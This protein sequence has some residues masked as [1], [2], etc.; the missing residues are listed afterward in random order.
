VSSSRRD[1]LR[2]SAALGGAALI[3]PSL[4]GLIARVEGQPVPRSRTA[5]RGSGGYGPLRDAGPELALPAGFTYWVLSEP[6]KPMSDGRPTPGAF[7][8]MAAFPLP[9]GNIRLIRNHENRD[10]AVQ[11]RLK[12]DPTLAYDRKGGGGTTSL[13]V[14]I[15]DQGHPEVV[16]DFLSLS[17]TIVNCAG[18]PTPWGSWLTCEESVAGSL[19]GFEREH[20]YVFEVPAAATGE[21]RAVPLKAMGRFEHEAVAIDPATGIVY[22]TEDRPSS[23]FYRFLPAEPGRLAAG[24]RLEMLRVVGQPRYDSGVGQVLGRTLQVDWV[25]IE[26]PDPS[27]RTPEDRGLVFLEGQSRGGARFARLEG[28]WHGDGGIFFHATSGGDAAV[29]QVWFF[30]PHTTDR[31]E[32]TLVFESP[33]KEVLNYPDNVTVSPRGGIVICEDGSGTKHVR[34]LTPDGR[35]FEFA[36]NVMNQS[37]FAGACFSPDGE[38]LFFNIQGSTNDAGTLRGVTIAVRGPWGDGAL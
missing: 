5:G 36:R 16:R 2:R 7:D 33:A 1:F 30:R 9:N 37:E 11:S 23:G 14:R 32:L 18:G 25:P 38:T 29:G 10:T 34:G 31:S 13:E 35:I 6:G 27:P 15:N 4:S 19:Q 3:A 8:G 24:G 20:G 12:G 22:L 26:E 17:G 21:V 28:C